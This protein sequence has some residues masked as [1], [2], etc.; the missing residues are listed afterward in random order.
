MI[1]RRVSIRDFWND[2]RQFK[3]T[4]FIYIGEI[5]RYLLENPPDKKDTNHSVRVCIGNGLRAD[6]WEKFQKRFQIPQI[7]EFYGSTEGN[8]LINLF[9]KSGSVGY[10][11]W[12]FSLFVGNRI[13]LY[14]IE[15]DRH[16]RA[17]DGFCIQAKP[18]EI[19]ELISEMEDEGSAQSSAA[20][21]NFSGYTDKTATEKKILTNVFK[22]GDRWFR[23]GDLLKKDKQGH[24]HFVDRIGGKISSGLLSFISV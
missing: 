22:K 23:T 24:Y 1:R 10:I 14:D 6:V 5:C 19:G 21:G 3:A 16:I 2:I 13:I 8:S 4:I 9:N 18:D 12:P 17:K 7:I 15:S 20:G 11:P